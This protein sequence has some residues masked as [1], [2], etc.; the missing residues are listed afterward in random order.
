MHKPAR[1][2]AASVMAAASEGAE[3]LARVPGVYPASVKYFN[4]AMFCMARTEQGK[5][6]M[7][8]GPPE[9]AGH[10]DGD[11]ENG[12]KICE[13]NAAN[14][15]A[16][17]ETFP[18]TAPVTIGSRASFGTGDRLGVAT[19]GHLRAFSRFDI[20]PVLAQQSMRELGRTERTAQDVIDDAGWGAFEAGYTGSFSAD[21]DHIK[22]VDEAVSCYRLGFTMFTIDASEHIELKAVHLSDREALER[23]EQLSGHREILERYQGKTWSFEKGALNF[24][25]EFT[26]PELARC[27]L[28]Y[29]KAIDHMA[30]IYRELSAAA[31]DNIER[32]D[33]E[34]S[35]D[36]TETD[37]TVRDHLF[38][39]TELQAKGVEW[40]SL[41][42]KF[43][44]Q[45]QKGID[46][47][48][49]AGEFERQFA[50]HALLAEKLGPYKIS[51]HSGSDKFSI[52]PLVGKHTGG[53]FHLKTAGTS[54][55]EAVRVIAACDPVLYREIHGFALENFEKDRASYHV[56]TDL[57]AIPDVGSLA[58]SELA[59]LMDKVDPRQLLHITYGSLLS[60]RD[61]QG[62]YLFRDRIYR[63]LY[64]HEEEM[65]DNLDRH[66]GR[67][68]ETLG[69][70]VK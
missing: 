49:D 47:I 7:I 51:V 63:V 57:E 59:A 69:V 3:S 2:I 56:T 24:S 40:Q 28:V 54:W 42:P 4:G 66:L 26:M 8:A 29:H 36:E 27:A 58:D 45:F 38:V 52:F 70:P 19:P 17:R 16:L 39:A 65:Y 1:Q 50:A 21:A 13:L 11:S 23:F 12:V 9:A 31:G 67:H 44:G 46:Y 14:A 5:R 33:F 18:W 37:T 43:T 35:V 41:A 10:F 64:D 6:L 48:G 15:S 68:M 32:F 53:Y 55:L 62:R 34:V 60:S 22:Q 25:I 20:Y 30:L 61:K